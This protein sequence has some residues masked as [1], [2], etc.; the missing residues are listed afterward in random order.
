MYS[1]HW[2]LL[3]LVMPHGPSQLS[4]YIKQGENHI[5]AC[6]LPMWLFIGKKIRT[7]FEKGATQAGCIF[8]CFW[9]FLL[10]FLDEAEML[11]S[12]KNRCVSLCLYHLVS[13]ALLSSC[14]N[15]AVQDVR[16]STDT[17]FTVRCSHLFLNNLLKMHIRLCLLT[18][19]F[20]W[21]PPKKRK[22]ID[23]WWWMDSTLSICKMTLI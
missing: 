21:N 14:L 23:G 4:I 12:E 8:S 16:I 7:V 2:K 3:A 17:A 15:P 5:E 9:L 11:F 19:A 18:P 10:H 13:Y 20:Q 1:G 6:L 22:H